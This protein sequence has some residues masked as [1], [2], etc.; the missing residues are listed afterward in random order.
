[1]RLFSSKK[2]KKKSSLRNRILIPAVVQIILAVG[3]TG[4]LWLSNGKKSTEKLVFSLTER[5]SERIVAEI[6]G[7]LNDSLIAQKAIESGLETDPSLFENKDLLRRYFWRNVRD[8]NLTF[9]YLGQPNG[10]FLG[11]Q[12][13]PENFFVQQRRS[14]HSAPNRET[15]VLDRNGNLTAEIIAEALYDHR[16]RIWYEDAHKR[17]EAIWSKPYAF[18][19]M[20]YQILGITLSAPIYQGND[21]KGVLGVDLTLNQLSDFLSSLEISPNAKTIVISRSGQTIASN[22]NELSFPLENSWQKKI[23]TSNDPTVKKTSQYLL[24]RY[25][26]FANLDNLSTSFSSRDGEQY[27][28]QVKELDRELGLDWLV[29]VTVPQSD[30]TGSIDEATRI[31]IALCIAATTIAVLVAFYTSRRITQPI[32]KINLAASQIAKGEWDTSLASE[33]R[34]ELGE[35]SSSIEHMAGQLKE[36][37]DSLENKVAQRTIQLNQALKSAEIANGA[38]DRFLAFMGDRLRNPLNTISGYTQVL[39]RSKNLSKDEQNYL[40]I[41]KD[42]GARFSVLLED[43]FSFSSSQNSRVELAPK[44][45]NLDSFLTEIIAGFDLFAIEKGLHLLLKTGENLPEYIWVDPSRLERILSDLLDNAIKFTTDGEVVLSVSICSTSAHARPQSNVQLRFEIIDTGIGIAN[46]DHLKIFQPFEMVGQ[47]ESH[48]G[49][50]IGLSVAQHFVELMGSQLKVRSQ[51]GSGSTFWFDV[52]VPVVFPT[53]RDNSLICGYVGQKRSVLV[54]EDIEDNRNLLVKMLE[55]IGFE[56]LTSSNGKEMFEVL[57]QYI[58]DIILLDLFMPVQTGFTAAKQLHEDPKFKNIP[59]IIISGSEI[60]DEMQQGYLK[61]DAYL[62][63]PFDEQELLSLLKK[64]LQLEWVLEEH[65]FT[66]VN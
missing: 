29:I 21:F 57:D 51:V 31:T 44:V 40:Q 32:Q 7:Y 5:I 54:V 34:D 35:L 50:G 45:L 39:M 48:T 16:E 26:N 42:A 12:K 62:H 36:S 11:V 19:S 46:T 55:P 13:T 1:M 60:T 22:S 28:L 58:P 43:I 4:Y 17:K 9:L 10:E 18:A 30:F 41:I 6:E 59:L 52:S 2:Q 24:R 15:V 65:R 14:F 61:C 33:R 25:G 20:N 23:T 27:F 37:F 47:R 63:K 8:N 53:Q 3:I 66:A 56:V 38:K 64:H 49:F